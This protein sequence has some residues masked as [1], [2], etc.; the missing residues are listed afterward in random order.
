MIQDSIRISSPTAG[1]VDSGIIP[2][3]TELVPVEGAAEE[4]GDRASV[5]SNGGVGKADLEGGDAACDGVA[6]LLNINFSICEVV[7]LIHEVFSSQTHSINLFSKR[8]LL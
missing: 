4:S 3:P 7:S 8:E 2:S 1:F 5:A 6:E